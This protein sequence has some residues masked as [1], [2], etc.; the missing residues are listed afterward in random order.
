MSTRQGIVRSIF[1]ST[2]AT[3]MLRA[4]P[5]R[6]AIIFSPASTNTYAVSTDP[7]IASVATG[8]FFPDGASPLELTVERHGDCVTRAWYVIASPGPIDIG[9]LEVV[10]E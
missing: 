1:V 4:N 7:N 2:A 3:I 10:A 6:V 8:L 5:K 9:Y